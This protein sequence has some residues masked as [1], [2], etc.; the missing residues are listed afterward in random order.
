MVQAASVLLTWCLA[1]ARGGRPGEAFFQTFLDYHFQLPAQV[2][3]GG[4]TV[5]ERVSI[6]LMAFLTPELRERL[7]ATPAMGFTADTY[8]SKTQHSNVDSFFSLHYQLL[9]TTAS[10]LD[11]SF[12]LVFCWVALAMCKGHTPQCPDNHL[13]HAGGNPNAFLLPSKAMHQMQPLDIQARLTSKQVHKDAH[14]TQ[15]EKLTAVSRTM[16]RDCE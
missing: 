16:I 10:A 13:L 2:K 5:I 3:E 7:R 1:R 6:I 11:L 8:F 12:N 4:S 15:P 9:P 14:K